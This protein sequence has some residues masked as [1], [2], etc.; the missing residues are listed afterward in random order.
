MKQNNSG[1]AEAGLLSFCARAYDGWHMHGM[2]G[3][4]GAEMKEVYI[5]T[6][7]A[8]SEMLV[9]GWAEEVR[10]MLT[11]EEQHERLEELNDLIEN[12]DIEKGKGADGL[13][14]LLDSG[15]P[16]YK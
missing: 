15:Q 4:R 3:R 9:R 11:E 13:R 12:L 8:D 2:G 7:L 5:Y 6:P 1:M 16:P 14:H 10:V